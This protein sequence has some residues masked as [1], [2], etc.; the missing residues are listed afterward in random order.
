VGIVRRNSIFFTIIQ[1]AGIILGYIN[2]VILF[3]TI[4][5]ADQFGLT[6][7]LLSVTI[8]V[9]QFAQLGTPLMVVKYYPYLKNRIL[10]YGFLICSGGLVLVLSALLLFREPIVAWFIERSALFVEYFYLIIPFAIA[11]VFYN[12][13]DAYLKALYKNVISA[14]MPFIILR[15]MWMIL[16]L[17]YSQDYFDFNTFIIA[18]ALSY[19]SIALVTLIY[20]ALL[21]ALPQRLEMPAE[22]RPYLRQIRDFNSF[23][24]L[25]GLSAHLISKVDLL[26]LGSLVGL[27]A[28][29]IYAIAAAMASVIR[30][31]ASAIA[32]TAP[33]LVAEAF[34]RNDIV[35]IGDLYRKSSI[36]Q[37]ILSGTVFS[38]I[39]LNYELLLLFL[40]EE[41]G[42]SL[43]IFFLLG[44]SQVIDTGVGINGYIMVNSR[45]YRIDALFSIGLL[46]IT[47]VMNLI[48]IPR[49]GIMG[50]ALATALSILIYNITRYV[51]LRIKMGLDPFNYATLQVFLLI[52]ISALIVYFIPHTQHVWVDSIIRTLL[53]LLLVGPAIYKRKY[54]PELSELVDLMIAKFRRK[55]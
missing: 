29:G 12:L 19:A 27:P 43:L 17:L 1:Y 48:F 49:F 16:I 8:V 5:D 47:V 53:F 42:A 31:P 39:L 6:R 7:I 32:R 18:Y 26:M 34:K 21:G 4:L 20:I 35:T 2:T 46:I 54:S 52:L 13:F 30:V 36:N 14:T 23:N 25:S 22:D 40:D 33:S 11:M 28:V 24:I 9:S 50:A 51:F 37:L 44:L 55:G 3:P 10:Y 45:F 15:I 41:Y 38:L